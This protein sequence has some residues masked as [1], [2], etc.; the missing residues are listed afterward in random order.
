MGKYSDPTVNLLDKSYENLAK[1][2]VEGSKGVAAGVKAFQQL[3]AKKAQTL[4]NKVSGITGKYDKLTEDALKKAR[5]ISENTGMSTEKMME[6]NS[7]LTKAFYDGKQ[8]LTDLIKS[9]ASQSEINDAFTKEISG[10]QSFGLGVFGF[11]ETS[12]EFIQAVESA[13]TNDGKGSGSVLVSN[14]YYADMLDAWGNEKDLGK[15]SVIKSSKEGAGDWD[16]DFFFDRNGNGKMDE[17]EAVNIK[18]IGENYK[19]GKSDAYF[20]TLP[21]DKIILD[22]STRK[23]ILDDQAGL[24]SPA[25]K[26]TSITTDQNGN[27]ITTTTRETL[28][29]EK[30]EANLYALPSDPNY[31]GSR[32]EIIDNKINDNGMKTYYQRFFGAKA[33]SDLEKRLADG[34]PEEDVAI[35]QEATEMVKNEYI[36][37]QVLP[38]LEKENVSIRPRTLTSSTTTRIVKNP[39]RQATIKKDLDAFVPKL[40]N[41]ITSHDATNPAATQQELESLLRSQKYG[42]TPGVVQKVAQGTY[43]A[44]GGGQWK[45]TSN[46]PNTFTVF[47][48][49]NGKTLVA[50]EIIVGQ[51]SSSDISKDFING[52]FKNNDDRDYANFVLSEGVVEGDTIKLDKEYKGKQTVSGRSTGGQGGQTTIITGGGGSGVS[53]IGSRAAVSNPTQSNNQ[54]DPFVSSTAD[55]IFEFES[56]FGSASG[57]GLADFGFT[58]PKY[59]NKKYDKYRE[60]G[61]AKAPLTKEG[62]YKIFEEE[63]LSKVPSEYPNEIREQLADYKFNSSMSTLDLMLL[64]NGDLTLRQARDE[65]EHTTLWESKKEEIEAEMKKDPA[66]F[67][68][69][70]KQ[71]KRDIYKDLDPTK[72][73]NTWKKR[74]EIFG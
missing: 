39:A 44:A 69:K 11:G 29:V 22:D 10:A 16:Y 3:E 38:G 73:E 14:P 21:E 34:T 2:I 9:G 43:E 18:Q 41:A 36:A 32:S 40:Q 64:A 49:S 24:N 31:R 74:I 42:D 72:Y 67:K 8:R 47:S 51:T 50:G 60:G 58:D 57:G 68:E 30:V 37:R 48:L 52:R 7:Q 23:I 35:L 54:L 19:S 45:K 4:A 17:G 70:I 26:T 53:T 13:Q 56:K 27:L 1:G 65:A 28:D 66:G 12:K 33:A 15:F 59:Q 71:A 20:S 6:I 61:K 46:D 55:K 25:F 5:Q 63:Y 62:A